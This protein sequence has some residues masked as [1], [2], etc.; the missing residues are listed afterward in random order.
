MLPFMQCWHEVTHPGSC[1]HSSSLI[2]MQAA[3]M[4]HL[5]KED[6]PCEDDIGN[7]TGADDN[8]TIPDRSV[9]EK[10][11]IVLR[12]FWIR[13]IIWE[14]DKAS[15]GNRSEA[16]LIVWALL[17]K[18]TAISARALL[19]SMISDRLAAAKNA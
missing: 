4:P 1:A 13:V 9:A 17:H 19:S 7:D 12:E 11:R 14:G 10:V 5:R 6:A 8:G 2:D 18:R 16:I 15:Q 3:V